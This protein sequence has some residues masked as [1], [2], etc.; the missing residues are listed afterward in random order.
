MTKKLFLA[1]CIAVM[2]LTGCKK[3][4]QPEPT[5]EPTPEPQTVSLLSSVVYKSVLSTGFE[6]KVMYCCSWEN[7]KLIQVVDSTFLPFGNAF[8]TVENLIYENGKHVRTEETNGGWQHYF[9]YDDDGMLK[10]FVDI[11]ENDT[12]FSGEVIAFNADGKVEEVIYHSTYSTKRYHF[13][14]E[15]GDAVLLER[16]LT[17]ADGTVDTLTDNIVYDGKTSAYTG[18]PLSASLIGNDVSFILDRIS[19]HN[20]FDASY[21]YN[22]DEKDR[23]VSKVKENDSTFY[24]YI[25]QTIE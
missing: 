5:P 17:S 11:N 25:E 9:T 1:A 10:T 14:W 23:L 24:Y 12:L 6:A 3:D 2:A 22:Y 19:K 21:T 8:V 16:Y 4:P 15:D 18:M 13:T 7:G 20:V